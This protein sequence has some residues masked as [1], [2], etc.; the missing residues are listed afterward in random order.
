MNGR[1][2][3]SPRERKRSRWA[4]AHLEVERGGATIM[5]LQAPPCQC[6]RMTVKVDEAG[7]DHKASDIDDVVALEL[8]LSRLP[9]SYR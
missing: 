6:L 2:K 4:P 8:S 7:R 1:A 9:Q 3:R 5:S